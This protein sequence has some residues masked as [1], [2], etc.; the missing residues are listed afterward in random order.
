MGFDSGWVHKDT[1]DTFSALGVKGHSDVTGLSP[2]SSPGVSDD[3]I[4]D[5]TFGT[6]TDSGDGVIEVGSIST[7]VEDTT[8]VTLE[9]VVGS[10]DGNTCWSGSDSGFQGSRVVVFDRSVRCNLDNSL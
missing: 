2:G 4:V 5:S 7:V 9:V 3:S 1:A 6:V 10:I 8:S